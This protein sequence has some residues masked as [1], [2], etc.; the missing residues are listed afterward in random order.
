MAPQRPRTVRLAPTVRAVRTREGYRAAT[1]V[2]VDGVH[3]DVLDEWPDDGGAPFVWGYGFPAVV[4]ARGLGAALGAFFLTPSKKLAAVLGL[5]LLIVGVSSASYAGV[6][7]DGAEAVM[8][9][10]RDPIGSAGEAIAVTTSFVTSVFEDEPAVAEFTLESTAEVTIGLDEEARLRGFLRG[11]NLA[12]GDVVRG[13]VLLD[14]TAGAEPGRHTLALRADLGLI[15]HT[16]G[17]RLDDALAL[18]ALVYE[19]EALLLADR[20]GDGRSTLRDLAVGL[21][22][23]RPPRT[24]E[25]GGSVLEIVVR[26]DPPRGAQGDDYAGQRVDVGFAFALAVAPGPS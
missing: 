16:D 4:R 3:V 13:H 25:E 9:I 15:G 23:L 12:P 10:A 11:I 14:A 5:L 7:D 2:V 22:G 21:E 17:P 24:A 18:D 26:F 19:G 6:L 20:D 1:R 8:R